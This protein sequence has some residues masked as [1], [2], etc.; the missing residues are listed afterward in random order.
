VNVSP[1]SSQIATSRAEPNASGSSG[2]KST[3]GSSPGPGPNHRPSTATSQVALS[4]SAKA[5]SCTRES[6]QCGRRTVDPY[7]RQAVQPEVLDHGHDLRPRVSQE[8]SATATAQTTRQHREVGH[9][10]RVREVQLRQVDDD[11]NL[12]LERAAQG[13]TTKSLRATG[14]VA[15][16]GE[17]RRVVAV[18]DDGTN[19]HG[20][21][22]GGTSTGKVLIK[23]D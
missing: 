3:V 11:V 1:F 13:A 21:R 6:C 15:D 9:Q 2:S 20:S 16:A 18:F 22:D 12:R 8:Q 17:N 10:R 5:L 4:G 14:L 23:D 7:T 19:L